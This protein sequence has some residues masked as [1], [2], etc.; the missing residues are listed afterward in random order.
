MAEEVAFEN[1]R[2]S[3]FEGLVTF[4][5]DLGLGHTAYRP[6]SCIS[7]R[8]LPTLEISLKSNKL[9]VDGQT[10]ACTYVWTDI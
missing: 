6:T 9:F 3:N 2:I 8:P 4:H 10:Y 1:G 7:H 5:L